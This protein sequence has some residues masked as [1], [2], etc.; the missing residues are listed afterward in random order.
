[1]AAEVCTDGRAAMDAFRESQ[2]AL[3]DVKMMFPE[4]TFSDTVEGGIRI[5]LGCVGIRTAA[6][7]ARALKA[8]RS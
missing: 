6:K 7:L 3:A 4:L 5:N 8:A 2:L 1:M